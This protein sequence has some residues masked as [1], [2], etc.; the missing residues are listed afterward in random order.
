MYGHPGSFDDTVITARYLMRYVAV[1]GSVLG[2]VDFPVP[3]P[4]HSSTGI[5]NSA[6]KRV[7]S[8]DKVQCLV[9]RVNPAER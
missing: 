9:Y 5:N 4:R 6:D 8:V 2:R 1:R 7:V 3:Y